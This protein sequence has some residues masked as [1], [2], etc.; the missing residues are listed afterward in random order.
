M[1][2]GASQGFN[3]R[4]NL[5]SRNTERDADEVHFAD[6]LYAA[7]QILPRIQSRRVFDHWL[8][9]WVTRHY[10]WPSLDPNK[11]ILL[12]ESDAPQV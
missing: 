8:W 7:K 2:A 9:E 4:V 3:S 10:I 12:V 11:E 1:Y 6:C 5:I